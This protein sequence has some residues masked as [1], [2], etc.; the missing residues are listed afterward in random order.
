MSLENLT[1]IN[2]EEKVKNGITVVDFYAD[3]CSPCK[4]I[5]SVLE[6]LSKENVDINF[7]KVNVDECSDIAVKFGV[8]SIPYLLFFNSG[9]KTSSLV[10]LKDAQ[11]I[12]NEVNKSR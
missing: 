12:L 4:Q 3:W 7:Y 5:T 6:D 2:F 8:R 1:S 10:G 11:T 9:E